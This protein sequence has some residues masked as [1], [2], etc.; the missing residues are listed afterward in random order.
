[1]QRKTSSD[2]I[3]GLNGTPGDKIPSVRKITNEYRRAK[4]AQLLKDKGLHHLNVLTR[5][6]HTVII[7][8]ITAKN[9]ARLA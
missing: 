1:L 8:K 4:V 9:S 2:K 7:Q 6:D 5:G 3:P